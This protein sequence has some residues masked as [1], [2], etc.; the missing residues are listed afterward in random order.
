MDSLVGKGVG[1]LGFLPKLMSLSLVESA[2]TYAQQIAEYRVT[3][4]L[5]PLLQ[6]ILTE[7]EWQT[8]HQ[9][10]TR[11]IYQAWWEKTDN[12]NEEQG[13]EIVRL[14][15]LAKEKEIAVSV[16]YN[17]AKNRVNNSR[18]VEAEEICREI[19]Q[20]GAD[21]RILGTIARAEHIL[22]F[23]VEALAHYEQALQLCPEDDLKE[24]A[25]TQ[26]NMA[27]LKA[28]Q[29]DIAGAIALFQ[30]SLKIKDCINDVR[31]KAAT[32]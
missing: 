19:L 32:L 9:A 27:A 4:I 17:I 20:L 11:K 22:G 3:T 13:R 2:T 18:Y 8:T 31:G 7:E 28:Q 5:E 25:T 23:V 10:A 21:Y 24:K 6:P 12:R 30:Q 29:G 26:H 1:G 14:A 15:V 16:G